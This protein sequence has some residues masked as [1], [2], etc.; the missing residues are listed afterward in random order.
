ME[1]NAAEECPFLE[2]LDPQANGQSD[3]ADLHNKVPCIEDLHGMHVLHNPLRDGRRPQS[4]EAPRENFSP[5]E[6]RQPKF[7]HAHTKVRHGDLYGDESLRKDTHRFPGEHTSF[8]PEHSHRVR[9]ICLAK[10]ETQ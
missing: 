7:L 5:L 3:F 2:R 4:Y 9:G 1:Q 6:I 8:L 10:R